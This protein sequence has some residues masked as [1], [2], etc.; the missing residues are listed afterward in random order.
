MLRLTM[1]RTVEVRSFLTTLLPREEEALLS[2]ARRGEMW[3][4]FRNHTQIALLHGNPEMQHDY[5]S[6]TRLYD[7]FLLAEEGS[8][9]VLVHLPQ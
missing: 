7:N 5:G 1:S 8:L 4:Q 6:G 2:Q 9:A 3:M